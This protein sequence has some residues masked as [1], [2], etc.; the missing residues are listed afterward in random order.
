MNIPLVMPNKKLDNRGFE[1]LCAKFDTIELSEMKEIQLMNRIDTKFIASRSALVE[2]LQMATESYR[3]QIINNKRIA[4][5]DTLYFDTQ[6][7]DMYLLHHNRKLKRQKIRTRTYVE[8]AITFLEIKN[9]NNKGRT[10]KVR[11]PIESSDFEDF[12]QNDVA[13]QLMQNYS[14]YEKELLSPKIRTQFNRITL[15]NKAKTERLTIDM[16]LV[17]T[18][19]VNGTSV[20]KPNLVII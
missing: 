18:N 12:K 4:I 17:F 16:D 13:L 14:N 9:K 3:M 7:C 20:S 19:M 6:E 11:V 15:V 8:S 5:Y 2:I 1:A 10:N